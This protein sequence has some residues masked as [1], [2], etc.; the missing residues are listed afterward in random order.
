MT[1]ISL[2]R[3][4]EILKAL[5]VVP[6]DNLKIPEYLK[7]AAAEDMAKPVIKNILAKL[8]QIDTHVS[9]SYDCMDEEE[10][11]AIFAEYDSPPF[12]GSEEDSENTQ[13]KQ[14]IDLVEGCMGPIAEMLCKMGTDSLF[15]IIEPLFR[16]KTR[17]IQFILFLLCCERPKLVLG[18][19]LCR[20]KKEPRIYSPWFCSLLSRAKIDE[21]LK[22]KCIAAYVQF[23]GGIK[24]SASAEYL[25]LAQN[26]IY[27]LCFNPSAMENNEAVKKII[28]GF[29]E[30][31]IVNHM[32]QSVLLKFC[33]MFNYELNTKN[34]KENKSSCLS[35]F[36]F[37]K[38]V[39]PAV[40]DM[41]SE[42]YIVFEN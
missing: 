32:N 10:W 5:D 23:I 16:N 34:I 33:E 19:L 40:W 30:N 24:P 21:A 4:M 29:F 14:D 17:N 18:W 35:F 1:K 13:L 12:S 25:V 7:Y 11:E 42:K 39:I 8:V 22:A 41:V 28:S 27:V 31:Q 20:L 3:K 2:K 9:A 15:A 38:P 6:F 26:L 36:P 37:D